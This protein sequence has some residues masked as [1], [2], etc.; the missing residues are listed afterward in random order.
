MN[1]VSNISSNISTLSTEELFLSTLKLEDLPKKTFESK[2]EVASF[3]FLLLGL[4]DNQIRKTINLSIITENFWLELRDHPYF[5]KCFDYYTSKDLMNIFKYIKYYKPLKNFP[6]ILIIKAYF[7]LI[8]HSDINSNTIIADVRKKIHHLLKSY[9][10]T[11]KKEN[12]K[13]MDAVAM[14]D[15]VDLIAIYSNLFSCIDINSFSI[16]N[17]YNLKEKEKEK[18]KD[19]KRKRKNK[20]DVYEKDLKNKFLLNS[21]IKD[22]C[23]YN[24][25][26]E[27]NGGISNYLINSDGN[28]YNNILHINES[29]FN[30][31]NDDKYSNGNNGIQKEI[32][33]IDIIN[34]RNAY[35]NNLNYKEMKLDNSNINLSISENTNF[36]HNLVHQA[37]QFFKNA[38][39]IS[40]IET[41]I[42]NKNTKNSNNSNDS[43]D[44]NDNENNKKEVEVIYDDNNIL[45]NSDFSF[46]NRK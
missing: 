39:S 5:N 25:L 37:H 30:Y 46:Q 18:I 17:K 9:Y 19:K 33:N 27:N 26:Y 1:K 24:K 42:N 14:I 32:N 31:L 40:N 15:S 21:D 3:C 12:S 41:D 13:N 6:V 29:K 36:C 34:D 22:N 4:K 16:K 2:F 7:S 11:E 8:F 23:G 35:C 28:S 38:A 10:G 44:S 45:S 20:S 43:N